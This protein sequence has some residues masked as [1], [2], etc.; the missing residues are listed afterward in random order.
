MGGVSPFLMD[1]LLTYLPNPHDWV[2]AWSL[3]LSVGLCCLLVTSEWSEQ[4]EAWNHFYVVELTN[5]FPAESWAEV[6]AWY[7]EDSNSHVDAV[8]ARK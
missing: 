6:R 4:W 3:I 1:W 2:L 7:A 5:Q 8:Y